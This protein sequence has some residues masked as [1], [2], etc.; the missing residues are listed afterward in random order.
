MILIFGIRSMRKQLAVV[1]AMCHRCSRPCAQTIVQIRRWFTFFFIPMI[2]VGTKYFSV[3]S[4]CA[5]GTTIQKTDAEDLQAQAAR[6]SAQ[7]VRTTPDGPLTPYASS[8]A[9]PV[10]QPGTQLPS[11]PPPP[12]PLYPPQ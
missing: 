3:C 9:L 1:L 8:P 2:P 11:M 10:P 4:M 6:Q 12:P 5:A 7:P